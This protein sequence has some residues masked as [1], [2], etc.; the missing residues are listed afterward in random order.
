MKLSHLLH[1]PGLGYRPVHETDK[2]EK[3]G[4]K[5][6]KER[7]GK[8]KR[9]YEDSKLATAV[10]GIRRLS[11]AIHALVEPAGHRIRVPPTTQRPDDPWGAS[12]NADKLHDDDDDDDPDGADDE[13][14][15]DLD[16]VS[17][18][19]ERERLSPVPLLYP[20]LAF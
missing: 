10:D 16:K 4:T 19:R 12:I 11:R 5:E 13:W 15:V 14:L 2:A 8:Q 6:K 3:E 17:L 18:L 9:K 20:L 1:G 7:R